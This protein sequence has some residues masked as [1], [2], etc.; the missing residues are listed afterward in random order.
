[1]EIE[2]ETQ[3]NCELIPQESFWRELLC[4]WS[5]YSYHDAQNRDAVKQQTIWFNTEVKSNKKSIF[6]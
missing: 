2:P 1:M 5:D 4:T 3:G 6:I